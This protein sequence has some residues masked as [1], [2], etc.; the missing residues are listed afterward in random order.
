MVDLRIVSRSRPLRALLDPI[1][2]G[3]PTA[4]R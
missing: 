1:G 3:Q 2:S 4:T